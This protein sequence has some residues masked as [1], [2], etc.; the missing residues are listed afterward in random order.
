MQHRRA[1]GSWPAS[2]DDI[3]AAF[4]MQPL[5]QYTGKPLGYAIVDG[6]PVVYSVGHD[7][8]DDR[9]IAAA[10]QEIA[11]WSPRDQ[12]RVPAAVSDDGDW[13]LWP[14][15]NPLDDLD[16]DETMPRPMFNLHRFKEDDA[17]RTTP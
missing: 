1:H 9:G 10:N 13:I 12:R 3:A 15:I 4:M 17:A 16:Y 14:H 6:K 7:G 5:D 8:D 2:M 11:S